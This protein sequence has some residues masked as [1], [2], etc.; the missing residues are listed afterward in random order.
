MSTQK[1]ILRA[2][3]AACLGLCALLSAP[4]ATAQSL[5]ST[6]RSFVLPDL[7]PGRLEGDTRLAGLRLA[8]APGWKTYWRAPGE[9]GVPPRFDWSGSR[10][11]AR[12]EVLW[13]RPEMFESFG[14]RTIGYSG[15]VVLPLRLVAEDPAAPITL[16]LGLELGVCRDICVFEQTRLEAHYPAALVAGDAAIA[17]ALAEVPRGG[18]AAGVEGAVC[19]IEGAGKERRF[20]ADLALADTPRH[21]VVVIEGPE[22]A[23]FHDIALAPAGRHLGVEAAVSLPESAWLSRSD[24]RMTVLAD[25]YAADIR[26]CTAPAG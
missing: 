9:A 8:I 15:E 7:L 23:W 11:L 13:P 21:P 6:G 25:G 20:S 16:S 5:V 4:A 10:N 26:G 12:V 18:T 3:A 1:K 2:A 24:I 17:L 14:M 22:E 19:R